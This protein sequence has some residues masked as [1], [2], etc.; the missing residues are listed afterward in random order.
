[1]DNLL[2]AAIKKAANLE[3]VQESLT[4]F[5]VLEPKVEISVNNKYII[6]DCCD[7]ICSS[8]INIL[9]K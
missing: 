9:A 5:M 4:S 1:M 2:S 3:D 7:Y 6:N 8:R